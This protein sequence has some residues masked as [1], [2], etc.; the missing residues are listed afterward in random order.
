MVRWRSSDRTRRPRATCLPTAKANSRRGPTLDEPTD[1]QLVGQI[2]VGQ[3]DA[4]GALYDRYA[5]LAYS[6]AHRILD[7]AA[8]TQDCVQEAFVNVWRRARTFNDQRGRAKAWLL[9]IVHHRAIDTLRRRRNQPQL[10]LSDDLGRDRGQAADV[11]RQVVANLDRESIRAALSKV[12]KAQREAIALAYYGGYTQR[13]I[14]E[15]VKVP[16]NTVKGRI[17]IGMEK[18]RDQLGARSRGR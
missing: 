14:A 8:D 12:P 11:W 4:L 3:E 1:E 10:L 7:N 5:K 15:R 13:E 2:A 16:L 9:S 6:L 18:L 17:R